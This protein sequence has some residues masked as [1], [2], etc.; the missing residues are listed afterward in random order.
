M[1]QIVTGEEE[2]EEEEST[3]YIPKSG[4]NFSNSK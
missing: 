4:L 1:S 2:E 3:R